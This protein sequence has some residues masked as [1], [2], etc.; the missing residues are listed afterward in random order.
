M[1]KEKWIDIKGY[2]GR[3]VVSS[4]GRVKSLE[5]TSYSGWNY[6]LKR[7]YP[8]RILKPSVSPNGYEIVCLSNKYKKRK[9]FSVH[10]LVMKSFVPKNKKETVNHIN[11]VKTDNRLINLEWSSLRDNQLHA[12]ENGLIKSKRCKKTGKYLKCKKS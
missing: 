5:K 12:I 8:E 9:F 4:L 1:T 11:G 10:R 2:K 7:T 3:Y 6:K